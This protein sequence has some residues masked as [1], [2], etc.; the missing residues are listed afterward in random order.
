MKMLI[1]AE[2]PSVAQ[3]I[4][5]VLG[6]RSRRDGYLEGDK[7][8][9][10]WCLGHLMEL[11]QAEAYDPRFIRWNR[12]D[13]PIV[14]DPWAFA[15]R[16]KT[17][18]QLE[19]IR[20]LVQDRQVGSIV[21]AT[22]AGREG[23]LI[24]RLVYAECGCAKP[25]KRLWISSMEEEAIRDGFD[26]LHDGSEYDHLYEAALCRAKADWL[27][28]I[29]MTRLL[30]T[31]YGCTL[32]VGRVMS[33]TLSMLVQREQ[34]IAAF[35]PEPFYTV[36][37]SS[38]WEAVSE[39]LKDK[40]QAEAMAMACQGQTATVQH[41]E[42]REKMQNPPQLYDLTTLQREANRLFGFAAKQTLDYAQSLYEK[43]LLT[44]PRTDSRYLCSE[45]EAML[46]DLVKDVAAAFP[47]SQ[48]MMLPI[49]G[50]QTIKN[51]AVTDHH[52]II[53]TSSMPKADLAALPAGERTILTMAAVRLMC[54]V[55]DAHRYEETKVTLE[56]GGHT[57]K[58]K[59]KRITNIGWKRVGSM[60]RGSFGIRPEDDH[61]RGLPELIEGMNVENIHAAVKAGMTE[62][63]VRYTE[64]A[65][66][67][68]MERAGGDELP[69]NTEHRGIGTPATRA[70]II[71]K[72]IHG[73]FIE[74][75]GDRKVKN[76]VPT[77]KGMNLAVVL[78]DKVKSSKMT[79][80]WEQMLANVERG[81]M[82]PEEFMDAIERFV[83]EEVR[84]AAPAPD[85]KRCFA[86]WK[87]I[88]GVCPRCGG[89]VVETDKGFF[90]D[91][92]D[93]HFAIWKNNR[94]FAALGRELTR[95]MALTLL[96]DG[97]IFLDN[98]RAR[99][100]GKTYSA[101]VV[102][103]LDEH[104]NVQYKTEFPESRGKPAGGETA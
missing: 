43:C 60:F 8:L 34:E 80:E 41:I 31:M 104:G 81:A 56:C 14:P 72:L 15:P 42:R 18:K 96:K 85:A 37:L 75:R 61:E 99:K 36:V 53:P 48:G 77:D 69:E 54:A 19:V 21:C 89:V 28:G 102:L 95:D 79:A 91:R 29:N 65:L 47:F 52:A 6:A 82:T 10:T 98:L 32:N 101:K 76:L 71:E 2:K 39:R 25:V 11:A 35:V 1:I 45:Q 70:G 24:F 93:C 4:A 88:A 40:A 74:R 103:A 59:G 90:C 50:A 78:P 63:P 30:S 83:A 64:D 38:D 16:E 27:V 100:T 92:R 68:A 7:A 12:D 66:L 86:S 62:A 94:F 73:G 9:I 3:A 23:E 49:N 87:S 44:Y 33:P 26:H 46:P 51:A 17:R 22:D 13:L 55:G 20:R 57:F 97:H 58:A 5:G 67:L 84:Y